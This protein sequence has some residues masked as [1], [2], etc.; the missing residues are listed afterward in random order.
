MVDNRL[1][2]RSIKG[3]TLVELSI[4]LIIIALIVGGI[5][6][7][8]NLIRSAELSHVISEYNKYQVAINNF[9]SKYMAL[10]GDI[11]N[12]TKFWGAPGGNLAN[13][14]AV[15]GTGKETCN[16]DQNGNMNYPNS[17][18][19]YNEPFT[20]WQH[21]A[22]AGLVE[23]N[24]TG[25][26]GPGAALH[27]VV[28]TNVPKSK[29]D[30]AGWTAK[31][32]AAAF[33]GNGDAFAGDY[34]NLFDF[35]TQGTIDTTQEPVFTATEI[36]SIDGKIDDGKPGKGYVRVNRWDDCTTATSKTDINAD[37]DLTVETISCAGF[38]LWNL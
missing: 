4:V 29:I 28:G 31:W 14:P 20:F 27:A 11:R 10:P 1:S 6:V 22:N 36:A 32:I 5:F 23:G 19:Q 34:G 17:A 12:A 25:R 8:Q 7:G 9:E 30:G 13:C 2:D 15:A 38:F 16:G 35:G 26:S 33:P 3:F 21:L 18:N 37:Y 24:Y